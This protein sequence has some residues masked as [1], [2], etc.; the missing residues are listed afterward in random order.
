MII[1]TVENEG[2]K[3]YLRG[4]TWSFSQDRASQFADAQAAQAGLE[5]ARKFMKP[6]LY[7][8][9]VQEEVLS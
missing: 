6:A 9:A 3:F 1:V 8:R 2:N 4:T 5:R 7:K